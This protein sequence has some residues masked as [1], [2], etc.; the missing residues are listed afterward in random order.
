MVPV[1]PCITISRQFG[2]LGGALG[3][4]LAEELGFTC[5]D[6]ELVHAVARR[7]GMD[8]Q[9]LATVDEQTRTTIDL[10]IDGLLR[11]RTY[12]EGEYL[13]QIGRLIQTISAHGSGIIVGRGGQFLLDSSETLHVRTVCPLGPRIRGVA[14]RRGVSESEAKAII[15][16]GEKERQAF[17]QKHYGRDVTD[18]ATYDL[19]VNVGSFSVEKAVQIVKTA[20][21]KRFG[22]VPEKRVEKTSL[23][24]LI[25]PV[26]RDD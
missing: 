24:P 23:P 18:P 22:D 8:E 15:E 25:M 11:G 17:I 9:M 26:P 3:Q 12:S 19:T 6:Q 10:F 5:W 2:A 1:L 4:A 21:E 7:S 14:Q 20:Y 13:R 16:K